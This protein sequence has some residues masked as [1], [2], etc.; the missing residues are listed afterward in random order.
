M[1][2]NKRIVLIVF[3]CSCSQLHMILIKTTERIF[4]EALTLI[5][6]LCRPECKT[7]VVINATSHILI[8]YRM[9]NSDALDIVKSFLDLCLPFETIIVCKAALGNVVTKKL[10][11]KK[12]AQHVLT[13][14]YMV[15]YLH[16]F[17][18]SLN[19]KN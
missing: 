4:V 10:W 14:T 12:S 16:T 6:I 8:N 15:V 1:R 17:N 3:F 2:K 19:L 9:C 18:P 7:N 5:G 13:L 11:N